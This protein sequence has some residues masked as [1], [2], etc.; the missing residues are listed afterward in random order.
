MAGNRMMW[1]VAFDDQG[2]PFRIGKVAVKDTV[3]LPGEWAVEWLAAHSCTDLARATDPAAW[4]KRDPVKVE[5]PDPA[6]IEAE[7]QAALEAERAA[8]QLD[9]FEFAA[10][11]AKAGYVSFMEA[12]AW[13]AGNA[14]PANL[15][16]IID[17]M[18][19]R[20]QGP[21]IL[22]V[23][24]R[25]I[26]RRNAELMP[27]LAAAFGADESAMDALFGIGVAQ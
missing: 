13:A 9:R 25:P 26:L 19:E 16:A 14:V 23:L 4:V 6:Q 5:P 27:A 8:A 12:A 17:R 15:Q 2:Q 18:P 20:Q 3:E 22:D 24:A 10:R 21:V 1:H 11:V 7:R